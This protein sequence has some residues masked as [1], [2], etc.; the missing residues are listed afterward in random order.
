MHAALLRNDF[1]DVKKKDN[2]TERADTFDSELKRYKRNR[3]FEP[4]CDEN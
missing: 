3:D 2:L 1:I 4:L